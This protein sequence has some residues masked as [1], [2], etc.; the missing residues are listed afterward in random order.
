MKFKFE[1]EVSSD[2]LGQ[3]K[4]QEELLLEAKSK[5]DE[6]LKISKTPEIQ[7]LVQKL[8][9]NQKCTEEEITNYIM[10]VAQASD[11]SNES[12]QNVEKS[13]AEGSLIDS[14]KTTEED[15]AETEPSPPKAKPTAPAKK[16]PF[17]KKSLPPAVEVTPEGDEE[18]VEDADITPEEDDTEEVADKRPTPPSKAPAKKFPTK[19]FP[20]KKTPDAPVSAPVEEE[21]AIVEEEEAIVEEEEAPAPPSKMPGLKRPAKG[22]TGFAKKSS[23]FKKLPRFKK[24]GG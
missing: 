24:P 12:S 10:D 4:T 16:F 19:K 21:E 3:G 20:F 18:S 8:V 2:A 7:L 6:A 14:V 22:T 9:A 1:I 23:P 11:A 17:K 5:I 15:P 13:N